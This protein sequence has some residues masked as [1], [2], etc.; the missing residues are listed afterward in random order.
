MTAWREFRA[1]VATILFGWAQA[2]SMEATLELSRMVTRLAEEDCDMRARRCGMA[3]VEV[4]SAF[5]CAPS[6]R[7]PGVDPQCGY[8]GN[9]AVPHAADGRATA[10][11][12]CGRSPQTEERP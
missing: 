10:C 4:A 5:D 3:L 7:H 8:C 11:L 12:A 9:V 1:Y 6:C 2:A